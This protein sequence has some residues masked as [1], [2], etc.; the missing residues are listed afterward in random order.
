[1]P[2]WNY[3]HVAATQ[4]GTGTQVLTGPAHLYAI[5]LNSKGASSNTLSLFDTTGGS[6][7]CSTIGI[8][9][10]TTVV[11]DIRYEIHLARGLLVYSN[12]GTGADL[13]VVYG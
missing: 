1:M 2:D 11:G 4:G 3:V 5:V 10:T 7:T 8:I 13:T 6:A 12:T 9:D